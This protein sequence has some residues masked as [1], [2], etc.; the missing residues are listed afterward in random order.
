M[1]DR[2]RQLELAIDVAKQQVAAS[3]QERFVYEVI[4]MCLEKQRANEQTWG[5]SNRHAFARSGRDRIRSRL[6][7]SGTP[8]GCFPQ[9]RA[10]NAANPVDIRVLLQ[11][12]FANDD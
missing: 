12:N 2:R 8:R 6:P 11:A 7:G 5:T 1:A 10:A 9:H 4:L 3:E